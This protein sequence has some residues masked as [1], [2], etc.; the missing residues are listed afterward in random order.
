MVKN[1]NL[2][3][4]VLLMIFTLGLYWVYWFYQTSKEMKAVAQDAKASPVLWL[5]LMIVPFGSIYS[6]YKYSELY[7]KICTEKLNKWVL[8]VISLVFYPA[9]WFLVQ[10]DLN[11]IATKKT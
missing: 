6:F 4:Q 11:A 9:I 1:R 3:V 8:F 2:L 10:T 5:V 7:E